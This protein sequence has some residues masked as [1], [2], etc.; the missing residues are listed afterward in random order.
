MDKN[1]FGCFL[2]GVGVG[3]GI[4]MLIAPEP[5][6][7]LYGRVK[8]RTDDGMDFFKQ[9]F[10]ALKAS[11]E[12][13]VGKGKHTLRERRLDEEALDRMDGEGGPLLSTV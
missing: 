10:S 1:V 7:Q 12:H 4:G 6:E 9:R 8:A 13:L 2:L 5:G 3:V 11:A